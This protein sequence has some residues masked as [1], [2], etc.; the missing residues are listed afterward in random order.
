MWSG[1]CKQIW[2][3]KFDELDKVLETLQN[4]KKKNTLNRNYR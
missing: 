2:Q 3:I 4:T 1:K